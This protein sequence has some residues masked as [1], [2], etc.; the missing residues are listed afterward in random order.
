MRNK[1]LSLWSS[2]GQVKQKNKT[3]STLRKQIKI[4]VLRYK[5][6]LINFSIH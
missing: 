6:K 1:Q 3:D 2:A 5:I 4:H